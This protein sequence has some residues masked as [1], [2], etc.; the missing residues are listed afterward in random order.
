MKRDYYEVLGVSK[1]ADIDEIKKTYR[2]LAMQYHPDQNPGNKEAEEKFKEAAEAYSVLSDSDKRRKYDQFG[3]ADTGSGGFQFDPNQF[4][5]FQDLFGSDIFANLFG[6]L[7]GDVFGGRRRSSDGRERG[8]DLQ[9]E[10]RLPFKD[11]VF[12]VDE[13]EIEIP[14]LE[15]CGSCSGSGCA[16]G[17]HPVVC[18]QCHGSGQV[19]MRQS[20]FHVTV[21]CSRCQGKGKTIQS[22]CSECRGEGRLQ[23][24]SKVRFKIPA[25]IDSGQR[26]R[27]LGEGTAGRSGGGNG[28]LYIAFN[29]ERDSLYERDGIDLHRILEVPW[30]LLVLGGDFPVETLYGQENLKIPAGT[31]GS[32]K[33]RIANAGVPRL[34]GNGRGDLVLHVSVI[35]PKKLTNEQESS[36]RQLL[37][38][39]APSVKTEEVSLFSKL[40][41]GDKSKKKKKK[42]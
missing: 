20:F 24:K 40:L 7:F 17:T 26:L 31:Q 37:E 39:M 34:K 36:V 13:K 35:V 8:S 25:G 3:H 23:N 5:D 19:V 29:V 16:S 41:S 18:P 2:K 33:M 14:R 10:L 15:A 42:Q 6:G 38:S 11:A 28:D 32:Q 12:G 4:A 21:P 22:P 30:P 9:I 1:N 27:L